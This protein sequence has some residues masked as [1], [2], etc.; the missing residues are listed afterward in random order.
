[1]EIEGRAMAPNARSGLKANLIRVHR[2]KSVLLTGILLGVGIIGFVDEAILHQVL[3]WHTF[4]WATSEYGRVLSDGFFHIFTMVVL[5]WGVYR[6]WET[7]HVRTPD[8]HD[9]LAAA[10][11]IGAGGF[12]TFD[13]IVDHLVLHVHLVNERVCSVIDMNNSI[14]TCPQDI[15]YEVAFTSIGLALFIAGS[16][17]WR[18]TSGLSSPIGRA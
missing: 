1:V 7:S 4:Y 6:L 9:E 14:G 3:Q 13:G 17:W 10:M 15:P 12:N 11:L 5:L 16:V 18:R 8:T 2:R